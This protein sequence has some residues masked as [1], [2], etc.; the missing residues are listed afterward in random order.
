MHDMYFMNTSKI[1]DSAFVLSFEYADR[2][3]LHKFV[4]GLKQDIAIK[5][6]SAQVDFKLIRNI[7]IQ[8]CEGINYMHSKGFIHRDLKTANILLRNGR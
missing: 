2:G 5:K 7:L 6:P 4:G 1:K 8:I 3:D